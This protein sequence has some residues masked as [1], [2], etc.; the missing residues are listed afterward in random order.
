MG[1]GLGGSPVCGGFLSQTWLPP[2]RKGNE[3]GRGVCG[4]CSRGSDEDEVSESV[5][6]QRILSPLNQ[7]ASLA[8]DKPGGPQRVDS[9]AAEL[10]N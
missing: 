5:I 9:E 4:L 2:L 8:G 7:Q 1:S 6:V 3:S 10:H